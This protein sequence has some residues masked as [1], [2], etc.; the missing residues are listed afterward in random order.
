MRSMVEG[1]SRPDAPYW[2]CAM[3]H[4]PLHP[5]L[6]RRSPSPSKLEEEL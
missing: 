3:P 4:L 5:R 1:H 6:R 2:D